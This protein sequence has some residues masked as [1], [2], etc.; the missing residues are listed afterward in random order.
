MS[1]ITTTHP[2][3]ASVFWPAANA[4][5]ASS[6]LR[7]VVLAFIGSILLTI[8]AKVHLPFYPVPMTMQTLVVLG[9]GMALGS[10]LGAAAVMLYM[11]EG[12]MGL[13]VF[14]GTPEKGMGVAYMMGPTGGYLLGFIVAAW[15]TGFLAERGWD[16]GVLTTASAMV[17]GNGIIYALG[18]LW[19]GSI[20]GWDKPIIEWGMTPFLLADATK[21]LLAVI[22]MPTA[23]RLIG[24]K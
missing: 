14:S 16:R 17:I 19:L 2:T 12:A 1:N 4:N 7:G 3:M 8:S 23:W 13:P 15:A 9:L 10:R 6:M 11:A 24:K 5:G 18:L 21:I 20:L 22:I